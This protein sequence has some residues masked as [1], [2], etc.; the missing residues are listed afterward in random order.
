MTSDPIGLDAVLACQS[1]EPIKQPDVRLDKKPKWQS[2]EAQRIGWPD[3][4]TTLQDASRA[5]AGPAAET[6]HLATF[7]NLK[8]LCA[9][10]NGRLPCR[11]SLGHTFQNAKEHR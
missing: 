7:E 4:S 11:G 10:R 5:G 6:G 2:N 8:P 9:F 3:V 1:G